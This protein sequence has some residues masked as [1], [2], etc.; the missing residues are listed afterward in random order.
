MSAGGPILSQE[1]WAFVITPICPHTLTHRPVVDSADKVYSI[2]IHRAASAMVVIDGQ[3]LIPLPIGA[4]VCVR[5]A[6][7]TFKLARVAG[8][9]FYKTL[10]DK[11]H[12]GMQPNYRIEP[13]RQAERKAE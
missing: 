1:L 10:H 2:V 12:W 13:S 7:V 3:D 6:P 8:R 4:R 11:L 9:S 5:R